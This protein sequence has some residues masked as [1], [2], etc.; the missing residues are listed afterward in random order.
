MATKTKE[1]TTFS[2]KQL[3]EELEV[4]AKRIRAYLRSNFP[5]VA[6]AKNT[7]WMLDSDVADE[8]REHFIA[9]KSKKSEDTD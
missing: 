6:E 9:A 8:V 4:D 1:Q 5:R 2:P 3:A 7:G